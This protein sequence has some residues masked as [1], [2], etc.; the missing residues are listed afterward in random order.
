[1]KKMLGFPEVECKI[2]KEEWTVEFETGDNKSY[3]FLKT[4]ED[5]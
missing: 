4:E 3:E 2:N 1:M 5:R